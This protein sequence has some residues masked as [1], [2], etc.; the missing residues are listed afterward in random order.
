MILNFRRCF[1]NVLELIFH[2]SILSHRK[3]VIHLF[4][5]YLLSGFSQNKLLQNLTNYIEKTVNI[6]KIKNHYHS[7]HYKMYFILS[8]IANKYQ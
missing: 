1:L 4:H 7:N 3:N 5:H 2:L 6:K 8:L